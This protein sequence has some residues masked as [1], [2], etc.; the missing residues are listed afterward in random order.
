MIRKEEVTCLIP[1]RYDSSRLPGKLLASL[2]A[3]TVLENVY[4]AAVNSGLFSSV[5]I[6]SGDKKIS[7][8]CKSQKLSYLECFENFE[9]G[10]ERIIWAAK[11]LKLN[12]WI[13]NLQGD[14]PFIT[15]EDLKSLLLKHDLQSV[16][17]LIVPIPKGIDD[18]PVRAT[19][20][21]NG[22]IVT[23]SRA[24]IPS[25]HS[26]FNVNIHVGVYLYPESIWQQKNLFHDC[27]WSIQESL[28]QLN[29]ICRGIKFLAAISNSQSI[30]IN[31][32]AD[33]EQA[34]LL[35]G[36]G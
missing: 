13:V 14:Q 9:S 34:R 10:S 24:R 23:F 17:T 36:G 5:I 18:G 16:T 19:V 2:G 22:E 29:L 31:T 27:P 7:D 35:L 3:K 32:H 28:E 15:N 30:E 8:Y 6:A 33:L 11:K 26:L 12:G 20:N 4:W 25:G 1:A 21:D